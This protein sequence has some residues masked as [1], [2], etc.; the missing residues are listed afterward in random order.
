[1]SDKIQMTEEQALKI[2]QCAYSTSG[3]LEDFK[4]EFK[5]LKQAG[6]I[7]KP[8]I[9]QK[10]M[11]WESFLSDMKQYEPAQLRYIG[12]A[13]NLIQLL[14]PYYYNSKEEN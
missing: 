1:M 5:A 6:Y 13:D 3:G 9:E 11:E 7:I 8:E 12:K 14:K 2:F 10:I 4:T